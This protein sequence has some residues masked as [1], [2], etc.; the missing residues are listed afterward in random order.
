MYVAKRTAARFEFYDPVDDQHTV[1]RLAM[2][3]E[4]RAAIENGQL[5]LHYQPQINLQTRRV[6]TASKRCCAG[7]TRVRHR[8]PR[9]I[10]RRSPNPPT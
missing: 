3:S 6:S 5:R 1:R 10:H 8:Q 4:L 9:G 2:V 7:R